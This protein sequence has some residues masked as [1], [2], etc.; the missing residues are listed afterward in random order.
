MKLWLAVAGSVLAVGTAVAMVASNPDS[1][2]ANAVQMNRRGK[3]NGKMIRYQDSD[4][5]G[6]RVVLPMFHGWSNEPDIRA[7]PSEESVVRTFSPAIEHWKV[8][9]PALI[10]QEFSDIFLPVIVCYPPQED[11]AT[12]CQMAWYLIESD[13]EFTQPGVWVIP[14]GHSMG[15]LVAKGYRNIDDG[16]CVGLVGNGGPLGGSSF[17]DP[18]AIER[19]SI[20]LLGKSRSTWVMGQI[21]K[22]FDFTLPGVRSLR[23]DSLTRKRIVETEPFDDS[24]Y[25]FYGQIKPAPLDPFSIAID[26]TDGL[27]VVLLS[28]ADNS[29][30]DV[31]YPRLANLLEA[32]GETPGDGMVSAVSAVTGASG[33]H[34]IN[35]GE[36]NH[37]Q[38]VRGAGDTW[39]FDQ[40]LLALWAIYQSTEK[41]DP[42]FG[43]F[44]WSVPALPEVGG[45][46]EGIRVE[47]PVS[48]WAVD[49]AGLV[50]WNEGSASWQ[51]LP[52][53]IQAGVEPAVDE[54]GTLVAVPGTDGV[55]VYDLAN[56]T[57]TQTTMAAATAVGWSG[58]RLL[59]AEDDELILIDPALGLA[60]VL[61]RD[62]RLQVTHRLVADEKTVWWVNQAGSSTSLLRVGLAA[63]HLSLDDPLIETVDSQVPYIPRPTL[64]GVVGIWQDGDRTKVEWQ[65]RK[66]GGLD[67]PT[68]L[69]LKHLETSEIL[70]EATD[71][72]VTADGEV[73]LLVDGLVRRLDPLVVMSALSQ[74]VVQ[75]FLAR[76]R[77]QPEVVLDY[78]LDQ[79]APKLGDQQ[80][81][82]IGAR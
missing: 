10:H 42:K 70:G 34:T 66:F 28:G 12:N 68:K 31:V 33:A 27:D 13:P 8:V 76:L 79:L 56:G 78:T 18:V 24:C 32:A 46:E 6:N 45:D 58:A 73:L 3:L 54:S 67:R 63:V 26:I 61:V 35:A 29:R 80:A 50:V 59:V 74:G 17:P 19:G 30:G 25:L 47:Y 2:P 48:I 39:L 21:N 60:R 75:D 1:A 37:S 7:M 49:G 65:G 53:Q 71:I 77:G 64:E 41:K 11:L 9:A 69:L 22:K 4:P 81:E 36:Y 20:K 43:L 16:K 15:V 40:Q 72:A 44:D 62:Q 82:S 57:V 14:Y 51:M 38:I 52:I 55:K 5:L 23:P